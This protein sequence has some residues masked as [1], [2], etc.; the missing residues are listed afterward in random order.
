[1]LA[2]LLAIILI[3]VPVNAA[4]FVAW[5]FGPTCAGVQAREQ[6]TEITGAGAYAFKGQAFARGLTVKY[7]CGKTGWP[8]FIGNYLFAIEPLQKAVTS[9]HNVYDRL[10]SIYGAPYLD[11]TPWQV[12][13]RTK[14]PRN[15]EPD[16]RKYGTYWKTPRLLVNL[17]MVRSYK[18][19]VRGWRA[20][21][22]I[23]RNKE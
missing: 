18:S 5:T 3:S 16:P 13:A 20:F 1:M 12:G 10:I 19:K 14:D 11:T 8:L 7:L 9:Y 22:V 23:S 21:V 17:V 2:R 4:A 15:I 6:G